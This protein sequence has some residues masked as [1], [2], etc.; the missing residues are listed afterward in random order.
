MLS[1]IRLLALTGARRGKIAKMKRSEVDLRSRTLR[2]ADG[3]SGQKNIPLNRA[4]NEI[5]S[6]II[7]EE[8]PK[9]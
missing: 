6:R 4:D 9:R 1:I 5:L 2:L 8:Q 7:A 3:K